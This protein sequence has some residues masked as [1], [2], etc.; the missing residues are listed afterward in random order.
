MRKTIALMAILALGVSV[1]RQAPGAEVQ[2]VAVAGTAFVA[3]LNDGRAMHSADLVGAVL[4]IDTSSGRLRLR[5]DTVERDPDAVTGS[6]WLHS[7]SVPAA[8]GTWRN[9]CDA[10]P[11]GR[12]QGFPLAFRPREP[13]GAME[14]APPGI[15]ELICTAGARGKC[16][17]FGYLPWQDEATR[18]LYN[19]CV[20]MVRAD[21]CGN[22]EA[23]T[24]DG[25]LID[26]YDD[27]R[28]QTLDQQSAREFEAGWTAGGAVCVRHVR[29]KENISLDALAQR[30]PR[31]RGALGADCTEEH[32]R[33]LGAS[34]FNRSLP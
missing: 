7:F 33:S 31:L 30:C 18:D 5:I 3:T 6:V 9:L 26:L 8:D 14:P 24:R 25:T 2:S 12:R 29:I 19:A 21:Y 15:F 20:R 32:A 17:R 11:D 4:T 27:R 13:D 28:I 10:G 34:L 22:G 1:A 23:T 16:V